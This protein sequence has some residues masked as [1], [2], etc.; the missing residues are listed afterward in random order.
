MEVVAKDQAPPDPPASPKAGLRERIE[1]ARR[2][3]FED[4]PV[5]AVEE[6]VVRYGTI[7]P[8]RIYEIYERRKGKDTPDEMRTLLVSCDVLV[9]SCLGIY[10]VGPD[11]DLV[12]SGKY[13]NFDR[14]ATFA[15]LGLAEDGSADEQVRA[16]Y[17]A[18]GDII[19]ISE[20]VVKFSGYTGDPGT[21]LG[22]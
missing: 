5:P 13:L 21:L 1:S 20:R 17:T 2:K 14:P 8:D 12:T 7:A 22:E 18:E 9:E 19:G 4:I 3:R 16:L 15:N 6:I 10:E 11:G